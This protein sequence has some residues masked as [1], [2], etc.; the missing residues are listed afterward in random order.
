MDF[1]ASTVLVLPPATRSQVTYFLIYFTTNTP[2]LLVSKFVPVI[3]AIMTG[4]ETK[5][6]E[7]LPRLIQIAIVTIVAFP[8]SMT[9]NLYGIRYATYFG[10]ACIF[11]TLLVRTIHH[12]LD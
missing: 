3:F 1:Y 9:K 5:E 4:S 11:Y 2:K 6:P 12:R 10:V 7:F 8:V